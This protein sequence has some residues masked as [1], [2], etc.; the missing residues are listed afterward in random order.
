MSTGMSNI[1][2]VKLAF[3]EL[4][5]KILK[6]NI[7]LL[8]CTSLYPAPLNTLNLKAIATLKEHF[9]TKVGYS[10]HSIG[11]LASLA[12][13]SMGAQVIENILLWIKNL[14]ALITKLP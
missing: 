2:E 14:K 11:S 12:A 1:S 8:H 6:K 3:A 7:I 10:D 4:R 9:N 5:K 13:V